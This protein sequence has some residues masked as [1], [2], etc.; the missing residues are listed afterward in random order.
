MT[1]RIGITYTLLR[2]EEQMLQERAREFGEV[3]MLHEAEAVLPRAKELD[4]VLIRN[5]AHHKALYLARLFEELGCA[6]VNPSAVIHEAGDKLLATLR[7]SRRVPVPRWRVAMDREAALRA[8]EE[9]GYPVVMKPL[10]GSWGRMVVKLND[11]DALEAVLEHRQWMENPLQ[12]IYLLQEYV[13]KPGRDIRSHVFGGKFIA[14]I[15]RRAQHWVTNTARGAMAEPCD[16]E[17]VRELS[18]RA[19][20]AFGRGAL[21]IDIFESPRGLLVDELNPVMEFK[22]AVAATGVDVARKLVE[23]AVEVARR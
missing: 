6:V 1:L 21:A 14:S 20:E 8:A 17:E 22:N 16:S 19:W 10:V 12:G 2:R 11:R 4:V 3:I 23:H 9:L 15:Y 18:L 13:E 5:V 7:L